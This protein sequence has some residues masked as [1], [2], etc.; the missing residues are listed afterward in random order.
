MQSCPWCG[1]SMDDGCSTC[2][3]GYVEEE[4]EE[5]DY[6]LSLLDTYNYLTLD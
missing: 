2:G 6:S 4:L 1:R 3:F 5:E